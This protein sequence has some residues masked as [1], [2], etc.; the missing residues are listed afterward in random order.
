MRQ[1]QLGLLSFVLS[2]IL[3]ST[4][5]AAS[6]Y[7]CSVVPVNT[8]GN[9]ASVLFPT[10]LNNQQQ[11]AGT[12]LTAPFVV[13]KTGANIPYS[14]PSGA[15]I[16]TAI[17]NRGQVA[18]W[19][20]VANSPWNPYPFPPVIAAGFISN[21][22]GSITHL[23]PP[24]DTPTQTF[25]DVRVSS[26]NDNGDVLGEIGATDQ[27]GKI[28]QYWYIRSADGIYSLFDQHSQAG[29]PVYFG[30]TYLI[31]P[32]GAFNNARTA[33][34]PG[35]RLRQADGSETSIQFR[36]GSAYPWTWWGINNQG[37]VT[38]F[39]ENY[40]YTS[41]FSVLLTPDGH[42]PAIVCP[43]LTNQGFAFNVND[44]GVVVGSLYGQSNLFLATPTGLHSGVELSN[45]NW[46]FGPSPVGQLGGTGTIYLRSTGMADLNIRTVALG[47]EDPNDSPGDFKLTDT[48]CVVPP[49][50][51]GSPAQTAKTF[52]PG[53]WCFLS[54]SF[55]PQGVGARRAQIILY[56]DAPDGPHVIELDATGTGKQK[57]VLS[58]NSW[59][60][61]ENPVG[62][63]GPFGIIYIYNPGTD[64]ITN[65]SIAVTGDNAA[66]FRVTSNNCGSVFV[67]YATCAVTFQFT[68][69][70]PGLRAAGLTLTNDSP[71]SPQFIPIKGYGY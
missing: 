1:L 32:A 37:A 36:G 44:N 71:I 57:L 24:P 49:S 11:A 50:Q 68:P 40:P 4:A 56:D 38:G 19:T 60:F 52:S 27:A 55:T 15:V 35:N 21:P 61:G 33:V 16:Q 67:P 28:V 46:S 63:A 59:M 34:L 18:G 66:D 64:P 8:D 10:S 14:L 22:D 42:A 54:F 45:T 29:N 39:F 23:D 9:L 26:I 25:G 31:G 12:T 70:A 65:S 41:P 58:N 69:G 13:D 30:G 2:I 51:F 17:N 5:R 48:T 20:G 62:Q 43:E 47:S 53:D 7:T 3:A 6:T